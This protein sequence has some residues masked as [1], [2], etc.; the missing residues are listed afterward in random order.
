MSRGNWWKRG[1]QRALAL[2]RARAALVPQVYAAGLACGSSVAAGCG[3]TLRP[4][5][6]WPLG[7]PVETLRATCRP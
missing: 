3:G 7:R 1:A 4:I 6:Q 5:R 2:R